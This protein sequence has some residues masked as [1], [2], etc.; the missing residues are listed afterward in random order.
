[1]TRFE[2]EIKPGSILDQFY[3]AGIIAER[4][5]II[6]LLYDYCDNNH[7]LECECASQ[8]AFIKEEN[9]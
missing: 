5:R 8:L 9:K 1:M 4:N 3:Q 7:Y 2:L 6:E